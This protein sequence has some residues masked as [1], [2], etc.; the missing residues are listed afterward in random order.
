M[1]SE[2]TPERVNAREYLLIPLSRTVYVVLAEGASPRSVVNIC[3][4]IL[5]DVRD[6]FSVYV[7]CGRGSGVSDLI[8]ERFGEDSPV[9][10]IVIGNR[11][12]MYISAADVVFS[13]DTGADQR[14]PMSDGA[15]VKVYKSIGAAISAAK[16]FTASRRKA[17]GCASQI[18]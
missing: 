13:A 3:E 17:G 11:T 5:G 6:D 14:P 16:K 2:D 10:T 15:F 12:G 18:S 4:S 1:A 7:C 8:K 9:K